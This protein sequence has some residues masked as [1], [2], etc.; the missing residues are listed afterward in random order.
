VVV[1]RVYTCEWVGVV[2]LW[3]GGWVWWGGCICVWG[4]GGGGGD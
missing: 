2:V 4:E 3:V 1:G